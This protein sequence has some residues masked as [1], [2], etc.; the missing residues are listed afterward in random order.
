M[1]ESLRPLLE[2]GG[3]NHHTQLG[4]EGLERTRGGAGH[5]FGQGEELVVFSLAEILAPEELLQT[6]D[7]RPAFRGITDTANGGA[8]VLLGVVRAPM[9]NESQSD[10]IG[11]RFHGAE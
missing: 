2:E 3:D 4:G 6:D 11:G 10:G 5:R 8:H 9:L 1:I 7:L